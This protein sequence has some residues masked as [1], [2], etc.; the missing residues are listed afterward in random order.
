MKVRLLGRWQAAI[1][2]RHALIRN[3]VPA[4][5]LPMDIPLVASQIQHISTEAEA[6]G[7]VRALKSVPIRAIGIDTEYQFSMPPILIKNRK[8][9]W[10]DIRSLKPLVLSLAAWVEKPHDPSNQAIVQYVIDLRNPALIPYVTELLRLRVLFVSHYLKAEFNTLWALGLNPPLKNV[11][12]TCVAANCIHLGIHHHRAKPQQDD[13]ELEGAEESEKKKS[14]DEKRAGLLSLVGQC[15]HYKIPFPFSHSKE[16]LQRLFL[17]LKPG[18][19]ITERMLAYAAADAEGALRVYAAQQQDVFRY[20]LQKQLYEVEFPFAVA[21]A[22]M[23]WNGVQLSSEKMAAIRE[24]CTRAVEHFGEKLKDLGMENPGSPKQFLAL[25]QRLNLLHH[26][27]SRTP[28]GEL[29]TEDK[30][31]ELIESVHP[32]ISHFRKYRKYRDLLGDEWLKGIFIGQDGR[33]HPEHHQLGATTGRNSCKNPNLAGIGKIFRP[34]VVAP[35]GRAIIEAD[36]SQVE[37]GVTGA[38]YGD[39]EL[40]EAYNSGDVY[41]YMAKRF[42][43]D[44][45]SPEDHVMS[46]EEFKKKHR[47]LRDNM[48]TFVLAVLYNAQADLIATNFGIPLREA[49]KQR[50]RFLDLFPRSKQALEESSIY[51]LYRGYAY[52]CL[53][54]RRQIPPGSRLNQWTKNFL[55]N[56]PIQ[57]SAA[58]IFKRAV[59]NL[60]DAFLGTE[61]KIILTAHD[62]VVVECP[63]DK[64]EET[65]QTVEFIMRN[66]LR[67]FYPELAGK[68]E[69]NK[70]HPQCWNK[71][72]NFDSIQKFLTDAQY[73]L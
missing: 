69:V 22:R 30:I 24:G 6:Q 46:I 45:L 42:Y 57:G 29:S 50:E 51:G 62:A 31:L 9:E 21:N 13:S 4:L 58:T 59:V 5:H 40:I 67:S 26:F 54:L 43:Q 23:E 73:K 71:D 36:Y 63:E 56:T 18:E 33:V 70:K 28:T 44:Q 12:D 34:V 32:A 39:P 48:K 2:S 52:T 14:A 17:N 53:G 7:M 16:E 61:T 25:M 20:G 3:E 72:G 41:A 35:Q 66:T 68:V 19:P 49:K 47:D 60:D 15:E 1:D 55:R 8:K 27:T 11:Y 64:I 10:N 37:V 65:A 38:E